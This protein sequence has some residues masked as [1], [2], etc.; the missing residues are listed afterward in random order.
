MRPDLADLE[1][2]VHLRQRLPGHLRHA[3]G[4][5]M[6][7]PGRP[8]LRQGRREARRR[9][10]R[11]ARRRGLG[12]PAR[13]PQ[14]ARQGHAQGLG[15]DRRRGRAQDPGRRRRVH[16]PQLARLRG[17]LRLRAARPG[18]ARGRALRRDQA[19]RV[20]AAADPAYLPRRRAQ[21]RHHLHR[22]QHRRVRPPRLGPRRPRP[23]LVLLGQH[24]GPRRRRAGLPVQR[25]RADRADGAGGVRRARRPVR[26]S[27]RSR[28]A[29]ALHPA[30][31]PS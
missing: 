13:G 28:S 1:L 15:R 2:D 24:R 17:R 3:P 25:D 7:H 12:A 23:R 6:L 26:G 11:P 18:A 16:L 22:G 4:R 9:V 31:S 19:R 5:R 21:R 20:L 14:Q 10:G 30:S 29:L 27:L 8:L